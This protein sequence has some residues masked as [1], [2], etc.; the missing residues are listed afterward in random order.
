LDTLTVDIVQSRRISSALFGY[1]YS[2]HSTVYHRRISSALF[3]YPNS[4]HSTE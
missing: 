3:G 4:G 1:P 2:G